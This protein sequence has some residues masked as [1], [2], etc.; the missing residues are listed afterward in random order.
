MTNA[1]YKATDG[2]QDK[3][4]TSKQEAISWAKRASAFGSVIV[5]HR[6]PDGSWCMLQRYRFGRAA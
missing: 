1:K 4:F 2:H 3:T 5:S 6:A